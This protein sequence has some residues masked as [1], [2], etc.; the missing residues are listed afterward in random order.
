MKRPPLMGDPVEKPKVIVA[1]QYA[2]GTVR[3]FAGTGEVD[4][5][6]IPTEEK[7]S[8]WSF[9]PFG[10]RS[11]AYQLAVRFDPGVDTGWHRP[12]DRFRWD[13]VPVTRRRAIGTPPKEIET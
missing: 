12:D 9:D 1:L 8:P 7:P 2:D 6:P 4:F 11:E 10:Y 13:D 3:A 5:E